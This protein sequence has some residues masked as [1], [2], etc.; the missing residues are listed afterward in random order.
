[1]WDPKSLTFL[2]PNVTNFPR[3]TLRLPCFSWNLHFS[4]INFACKQDLVYL[5]SRKSQVLI[6]VIAELPSGICLIYIIVLHICLVTFISFIFSLHVPKSN[7]F[8]SL[9]IS[10]SFILQIIVH[11]IHT[12]HI[13]FCSY[14]IVFQPH[15]LYHFSNSPVS[16]TRSVFR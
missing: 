2:S 6:P 11:L 15:C 16:G 14:C 3:C 9:F 7:L 5:R 4:Q 10:I 13:W 8:I 12:Q 1:M